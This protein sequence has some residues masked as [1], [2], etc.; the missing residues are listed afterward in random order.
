MAKRIR[1][2][3]IYS[4]DANPN[5]SEAEKSNEVEPEVPEGGGRLRTVGRR[6]HRKPRVPSPAPTGGIRQSEVWISYARPSD[7]DDPRYA[8]LLEQPGKGQPG[9]WSTQDAEA[10]HLSG[11]SEDRVNAALMD[12]TTAFNNVCRLKQLSSDDRKALLSRFFAAALD[13]PQAQQGARSVVADLPFQAPELWLERDRNIKTNPAAFVR[14]VYG[15]WIGKGMKRGDLRELDK[16]LYQALA[17]WVA[18]HPEDDL[19]ELSR[20]SEDVDRAIAEL[21][22]LYDPDLLRRLGLALQSRKTRG[23]SV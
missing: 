6:G 23:N 15:A 17:N 7:S 1:H 11:S 10:A 13:G 2:R 20:Q 19:P 9:R 3:K 4:T 22:L 5:A 14:R 21:S 16:P 18:R 8:E 12:L